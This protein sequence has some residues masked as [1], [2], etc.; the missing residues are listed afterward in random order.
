MQKA[1]LGLEHVN[2]DIAKEEATKQRD[3]QKLA[4]LDEQQL[5][6]TRQ[7][8]EITS[9]ISQNTEI[10]NDQEEQEVEAMEDSD[11]LFVFYTILIKML[12]AKDIRVLSPMLKDLLKIILEQ[13]KQQSISCK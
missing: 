10:I 3:Y 1:K 12:E 4:S 7:M 6:I 5:A 2:L 8:N 9:R 13:V 11:T